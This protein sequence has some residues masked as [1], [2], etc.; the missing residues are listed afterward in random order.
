MNGEQELVYGVVNG[1]GCLFKSPE[2]T[3]GIIYL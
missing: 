2:F 1:M 3:A